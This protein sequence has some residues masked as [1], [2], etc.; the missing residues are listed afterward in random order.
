MVD[1]A[2]AGIASLARVQE[3]ALAQ[4]GVELAQLMRPDTSAKATR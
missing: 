2:L 3:Q 4:A 1:L